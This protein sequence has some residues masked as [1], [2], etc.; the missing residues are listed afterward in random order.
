LSSPRLIT[1]DCY[2]TLIDWYGGLRETL[3]RLLPG[4]DM[5]GLCDR[6]VE[7]EMEVESGPYRSYREVMAATLAA[8]MEEAGT[9]VAETERDA[10]GQALPGWT[11]Y[12]EVPAVLTRL[13]QQ[14]ALGILSNIDDDL[15]AASVARLG[16]TPAHHVTA[17]QVRSYKPGEA[18]FQRILE[19]SGLQPGEILHVAGSLLHDMVPARRLGFRH[20][21]VNRLNEARPDWLAPQQEVKDLTSLPD[22]AGAQSTG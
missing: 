1:F 5:D 21:W 22:I 20:L 17:T 13:Q 14:H 2:G 9:P 19:I 16:V 10:L 6:Y 12:P 3:S 15:L 7:L 4:A 18:H 8:L 11:P